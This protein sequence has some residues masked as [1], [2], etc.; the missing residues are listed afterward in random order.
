MKGFPDKAAGHF[1]RATE[2]DPSLPD[3][4]YYLGTCSPKPATTV[5]PSGSFAARGEAQ[6]ARSHF[7]AAALSLDPQLRSASSRLR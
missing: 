2:I 5:K 4:H 3:A 6:E 1:R 7:A